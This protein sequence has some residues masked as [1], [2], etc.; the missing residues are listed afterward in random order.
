MFWIQEIGNKNGANNP[1]WKMFHCDYATDITKLPTNTN[2]GTQNTGEES[3]DLI[4]NSLAHYGDQCFCLENKSAYELGKEN[5]SW[6][7]L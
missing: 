6:T 5:D 1:N 4:A 2:I 7:K 3:F